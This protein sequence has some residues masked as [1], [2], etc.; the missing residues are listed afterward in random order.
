[1]TFHIVKKD[2]TKMNVDAIVN[3]AN[4]NLTR[5]QGVC[6]SIFAAADD[7]NLAKECDSISYCPTGKAIITKD[8]NLKSKYIIHAI[9][10]I[11]QGGNNDEK[12]LLYDAY[13]NSLTLLVKNNLKSIAFPLISSGIYGYP[14]DKALDIAI[15][16]IESFLR[17]YDKEVYLTLLDNSK[18][19]ISSRLYLNI[20]D[21]I[22]ENNHMTKREAII[23][24]FENSNNKSIG[25][26]NK[27]LFV[28]DEKL[29]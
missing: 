6:S 20:L 14:K 21:F 27:V 7:D 23:K 2:I 5:G 15:S 1:M 16:A 9:G 13:Y 17:K 10:P 25:T 8:Y 19:L 29:I 18:D 22:E 3:A 24:F 28:F 4:N 12:R 11:W 26:I